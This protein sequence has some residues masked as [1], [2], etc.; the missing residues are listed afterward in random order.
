MVSEPV[1]PPNVPLKG[2]IRG[3]DVDVPLSWI[4]LSAVTIT[5]LACGVTP[6]RSA[7]QRRVPPAKTMGPGPNRAV[8]S[9]KSMV[10][11]LIVV[12]PV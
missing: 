9:L 1:S 7:A 2:N 6:L 8:L 12:G 4:T 10:P 5:G 3:A 11:S